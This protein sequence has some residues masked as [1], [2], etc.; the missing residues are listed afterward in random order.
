MKRAYLRPDGNYDVFTQEPEIVTPEQWQKE[1]RREALL[2]KR[3]EL[4]AAI[5]AVD[6][7]LREE[8]STPSIEKKR[9]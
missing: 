1:Q 2:K 8:E 9:W 5:E 3:A 4:Q 6:K 7:E